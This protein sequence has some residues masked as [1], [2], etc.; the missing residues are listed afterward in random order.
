MLNSLQVGLVIFPPEKCAEM[1]N[2]T[3]SP[4]GVDSEICAGYVY[5]KKKTAYRM[6]QDGNKFNQIKVI[7]ITSILSHFEFDTVHFN[8]CVRF[9]QCAL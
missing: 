1:L 5:K 7:I 9:G 6:L 8:K 3:K 2:V 4:F